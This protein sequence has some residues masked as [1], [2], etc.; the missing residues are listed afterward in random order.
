MAEENQPS[1]QKVDYELKRSVKSGMGL[2][3]FAVVMTVVAIAAGI[4]IVVDKMTE[5]DRINDAVS[6]K[7]LTPADAKQGVIDDGTTAPE[8]NIPDI[9]DSTVTPNAS[10]YIYVADWGVKVKKP[11][12]YYIWYRVIPDT[13]SA[14]GAR[15]QISGSKKDAQA[16]VNYGNFDNGGQLINVLRTTNPDEFAAAGSAPVLIGRVGDYY[17]F[18]NGPQACSEA[19]QGNTQACQDENA[20]F[21][22]LKDTFSNVNNWST[23]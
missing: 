2:V 6:Q 8:T 20:V 5:Q 18:Y 9:A 1:A 3:V 14:Y 12:N 19:M 4:Y 22:D 11:E 7:C 13:G 16:W 10:D 21:N 17:Y 15:L 23:F